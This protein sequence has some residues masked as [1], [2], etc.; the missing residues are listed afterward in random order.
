MLS[1]DA[2]YFANP[3]FIST[4]WIKKETLPYQSTAYLMVLFFK[5]VS[6]LSN[7]KL[8]KCGNVVNCLLHL[9]NAYCPYFPGHLKYL[10]AVRPNA[11]QKKL[12]APG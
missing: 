10:A 12:K 3:L 11:Q 2:Y 1:E 4:T 5:A 6:K 8:E 9:L 7:V